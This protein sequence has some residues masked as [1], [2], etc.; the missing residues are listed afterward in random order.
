MKILK[1]CEGAENG[2][3][4]GRGGHINHQY[5]F[6]GCERIFT[7]IT[8]V[9]CNFR[10]SKRI[11]VLKYWRVWIG[12]NRKIYENCGQINQKYF[13]QGVDEAFWCSFF[14]KLPISLFQFPTFYTYYYSYHT[15]ALHF[16]LWKFMRKIPTWKIQMSCASIRWNKGTYLLIPSELLT[17]RREI[18]HF[19]AYFW[20]KYSKNTNVFRLHT[21]Q[22]N[23]SVNSK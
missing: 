1:K 16:V 6:T 20:V 14:F 10:N 19:L 5:I 2:K 17:N 9:K 15:E 11:I 12:E 3:I 7:S 8:S 23:P 4:Y 18:T 21:L 22:T 13:L